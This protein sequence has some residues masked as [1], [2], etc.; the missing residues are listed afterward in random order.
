MTP[1][2]LFVLIFFAV[3]FLALGAL[4]ED[5]VAKEIGQL[6]E[7]KLKE[8]NLQLNDKISDETFLR[9]AYLD[10][11]GRIPTV[12][13]YEGFMKNRSSTRRKKLVDQLFNS[14]GYVSHSFNY[15]ADV[16]RVTDFLKKSTGEPYKHWLKRSL[17]INQ[18]YDQFTHELLSAEGPLF[19]PGNG[20]VG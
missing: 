8:M 9:R 1:R 11:V 13:E 3:H 6:V 10:I 4:D 5:K 12:K 19:K 2:A 18:P 20:A 7:K 15:W 17:E 16:L 14:I